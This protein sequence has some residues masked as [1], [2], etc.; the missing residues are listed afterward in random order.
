MQEILFVISITVFEL[1][2]YL[3]AFITKKTTDNSAVFL[4]F[5]LN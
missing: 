3:R 1:S 5:L 2:D 4:L